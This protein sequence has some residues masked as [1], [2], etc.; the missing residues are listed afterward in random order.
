M[1]HCHYCKRS[2]RGDEITKDHRRPRSRG[3]SNGANVVPCCLACNRAKGDR[4]EA[5]F[6]A[7]VMSPKE[8]RRS[9]RAWQRRRTP[10]ETP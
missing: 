10:K 6:N 3:G 9:L 7:G 4:T 8:T 2:I 5:E 1:T